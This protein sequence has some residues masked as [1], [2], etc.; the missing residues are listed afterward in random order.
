[1][2]NFDF[3]KKIDSNLYE[4]VTEAEKLYASEFFEQCMG[5]TRRF[6]EQMCKAI[7]A[8]RR[9]FDGSF[10]EML[11]TLKDQA[12]SIPEKEFIDD[13]YF[14]KKQGNLSVHSS[15]VKKDGVV[16]LEC[17]QRAFE[18]AINYAV[19]YKKG[20]KTILK[21][22]YDIELLVTGKSGLSEKYQSE[23]QTQKQVEKIKN[24]TKKNK[25]KIVKQS[26]TMKPSKAKKKNGLSAFWIFV[27]VASLI[28]LIMLIFIA[29][30]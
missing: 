9:Q 22:H 2:T 23:K 4:I 5:Q 10:D 20:S 11:A 12:T 8:E 16:A 28:S 15:T 14:L 13:L 7:L 3:L 6:G 19:F 25:N 18:A 29:L 24:S 26:Y 30:I 21:K 27:G 17:L 1:M